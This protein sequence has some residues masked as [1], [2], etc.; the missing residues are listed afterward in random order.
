MPKGRKYI[1]KQNYCR[2]EQCVS[3]RYRSMKYI[4]PV[5]AASVCIV[6]DGIPSCSHPIQHKQRR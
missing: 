1:N 4:R 6:H 3:E 2:L 5:I